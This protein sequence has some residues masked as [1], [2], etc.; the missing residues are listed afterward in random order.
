MT[1]LTAIGLMSGT[2]LDGID[3]ALLRTD[4]ENVVEPGESL[5]LRY[6]PS[7]RAQLQR[8]VRAAIEGR[9]AAS[10]I[11]VAAAEVVRIHARAVGMLLMKAG[12]ARSEVDVVGFHGQTILHRPPRPPGGRGRS[13]QIGDGAALAA[14]TRI[15]VVNE[16]RRADIEAGGEGAPLVPV[17]HAAL[18][19]QS[20]FPDATAVLNL[21]GVANVTFVPPGGDD[22]AL[23]AFDCGPG[24]GLIDQWMELK[25]GRTYD[26]DGA[27]ALAGA[28][29]EGV[30]RRLLSHSYFAR[31]PPK[32][33]DRYD[34][35]LDPALGLSVEDG[36]ATLVRFTAAA[37]AKSSAF[38]PEPPARWIVCG[39][40]RRNPALMAALAEALPAPVLPAEAFGWR[41][42][43]LEAESFAY[44]AVRALRGLPISFPGTTGAPRPLAGGVVHRPA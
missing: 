30:L 1:V 35:A 36:A 40:G 20:G 3:A 41:S 17:Y 34:F 12:L 23:L 29:D 27:A 37:V 31:R 19:R 32:S 7:V 22:A 4:G 21:G 43:S 25:T 13:W 15:A 16:F 6:D 24:N 33:L 44:L 9:D 14:Q 28:P 8:A 18:A 10:D 26:V 38:L 39:G 42:D 11:G 5:S 2:S